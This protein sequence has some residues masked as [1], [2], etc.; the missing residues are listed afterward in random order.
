M[1]SHRPEQQSVGEATKG[2]A[3]QTRRKSARKPK[4]VACVLAI[5]AMTIPYGNAESATCSAASEIN[6][7]WTAQ[8]ETGEIENESG[9]LSG[10]M[11]WRTFQFGTLSTPTITI[12]NDRGFPV[13]RTVIRLMQGTT[14]TGGPRKLFFGF[15]EGNWGP[16]PKLTLHVGPDA[17]DLG[18]ADTLFAKTYLIPLEAKWHL[19]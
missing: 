8:L 16:D 6:R 15:S 12:G 10:F 9:P 17:Y 14:H 4:I 19:V 18:E 5:T 13:T 2:T 7:V 11:N 1:I 3:N